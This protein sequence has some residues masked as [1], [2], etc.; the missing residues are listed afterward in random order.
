MRGQHL[1]VGEE[2][3]KTLDIMLTA[4]HLNGTPSVSHIG[5][6]ED[7][8]GEVYEKLGSYASRTIV[9]T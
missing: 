8:D 6:G 5:I 4:D 3:G 2:W 1:D 9:K 7:K